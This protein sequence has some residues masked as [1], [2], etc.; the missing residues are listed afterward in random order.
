MKKGTNVVSLLNFLFISNMRLPK[1]I[2]T[3][4]K[5][6]LMKQLLVHH[7]FTITLYFGKI[8]LILL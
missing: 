3:A 7:H 5:N 8:I 4:W 1:N 2:V 6:Y